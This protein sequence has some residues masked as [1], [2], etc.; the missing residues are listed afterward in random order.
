M[1]AKMIPG[2]FLVL[3]LLVSCSGPAKTGIFTSPTQTQ[4]SL[5]TPTATPNPMPS[6]VI[7]PASAAQVVQL[8]S[9]GDPLFYHLSYSPDGKWLVVTTSA[10]VKFY[11]AS[12]LAP[13]HPTATEAWKDIPVISPDGKTVAFLKDSKTI[14]LL[15]VATG[16][17]V[18]TLSEQ[19][20]TFS[21]QRI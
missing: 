2:L 14:T 15:D 18:Q 7:G 9:F 20:L 12:S 11:D 16:A 5:P 21:G 6:V 13:I 8:A 17:V 1:N 19:T 4:V 3:F 10:G